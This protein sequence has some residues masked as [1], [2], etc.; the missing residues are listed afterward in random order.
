[1]V[2]VTL[3]TIEPRKKKTNAKETTG[4]EGL[5]LNS[6]PTLLWTLQGKGFS[7]SVKI[8]SLKKFR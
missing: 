4:S 7:E 3:D 6:P 1:M 5:E 8:L 2:L